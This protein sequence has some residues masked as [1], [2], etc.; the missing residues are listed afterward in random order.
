MVGKVHQRVQQVRHGIP[1]EPSRT[2]LDDGQG[3]IPGNSIDG[4]SLYGGNALTLGVL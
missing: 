2:S 4:Y 3:K 1:P